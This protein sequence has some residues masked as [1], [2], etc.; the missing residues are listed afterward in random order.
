MTEK[1]PLGMVPYNIWIDKRIEDL[2]EG[3]S[4]YVAEDRYDELVEDWCYEVAQ[5]IKSMRH[6]RETKNM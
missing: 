5:L 6:Y 2:L 3:I 4:R 1:P